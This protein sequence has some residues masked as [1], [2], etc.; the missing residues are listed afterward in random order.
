MPDCAE[1]GIP[2]AAV[3]PPDEE[4]VRRHREEQESSRGSHFA[5][6]FERHHKAVV[7]WACRMTGNAEVARDLAQDV[8]LKAFTRIDAYRGDSRFSTW[9]YAITRNCCRDLARARGARVAE[10]GGD[11]A[12]MAAEPVTRNAA[13]VSLDAEADRALATMLMRD[14]QL[15]RIE[16]RVV[17]LHYAADVPLDALSAM[18]ALR[19]PSGA[20]ASIVSAKRKLR[21]AVARWKTRSRRRFGL[22]SVG[23]GPIFGR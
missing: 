21:L 14:A 7:A 10:V 23:A 18:L 4:L 8:F 12:L 22:Q 17:A 9:L 13:V 1:A 19:N 2:C 3:W 5:T 20:R 16:R 15:T 6:L 11:E